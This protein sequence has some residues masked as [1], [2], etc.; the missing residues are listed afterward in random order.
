MLTEALLA[1]L[2]KLA[3]GVTGA[4]GERLLEAAKVQAAKLQGLLR[5][6]ENEQAEALFA[7]VRAEAA[8]YPPER[9]IR[10]DSL[11]TV[12]EVGIWPPRG[13]LKLHLQWTNHADFPVL[14]RDVAIKGRVGGKNPE[15]EL[16]DGDEFR[17]EARSQI[18]RLVSGDPHAALPEF[19]R[20]GVACELSVVALVAGPWEGK[21]QRTR[22]LLHTSTWLPVYVDREDLLTA[23]ADIDLVLKDYLEG[24][25]DKGDERARVVY[26]ELD[27]TL[28]LRPGAT[29]DRLKTVATKDQHQVE[30]GP[31]VAL[32]RFTR[33]YSG[34]EGGWGGSID[35]F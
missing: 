15:W 22:D 25:V 29:K 21:A 19:E 5:G 11:A 31:S 14:V 12:G 32:V 9:A 8:A 1:A 4:A 2:M 30:V 16:R 34:P 20:G 13:R 10:V 26:S 27:H 33:P 28:R 35:D 3:E 17:I 6:N 24:L 18:T 7:H 23:D